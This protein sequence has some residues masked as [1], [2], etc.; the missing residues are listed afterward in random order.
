MTRNEVIP[1]FG[2]H[3]RSTNGEIFDQEKDQLQNRKSSAMRSHFV[4]LKR[5]LKK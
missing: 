1:M 5:D 2:E 3:M 4:T